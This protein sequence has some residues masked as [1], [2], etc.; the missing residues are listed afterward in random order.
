MLYRHRAAVTVIQKDDGGWA[1][2]LTRDLDEDM[3]AAVRRYFRRVGQVAT[4]D[5][6]SALIDSLVSEDWQ[7]ADDTLR[8]DWEK[9]INSAATRAGEQA[10]EAVGSEF[11]IDNPYTT[12]WLATHGSE[13]ITHISDET[14]EAVRRAIWEGVADHRAPKQIAA[15]LRKQNLVGLLP[16]HLQAVLTQKAAW[17]AE[18]Y[19]EW[20]VAEMAAT[21]AD[22]LLNYR[23]MNIA[24]TEVIRGLAQGTQ[25]SWLVARQEGL[26]L[27]QTRKVWLS[28]KG[29]KRTCPICKDLHRVEAPLDGAFI[30]PG[31]YTAHIPPAHPG[32]RCSMGLVTRTQEE[33]EAQQKSA[34][35]KLVYLHLPW[36]R[37]PSSLV[38]A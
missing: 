12:A 7:A 32:C 20:E 19:A 11:L 17:L 14:R 5:S 27:P 26:L 1:L 4:G 34:P 37:F 16:Q 25:D 2:E 10:A 6:V 24:R 23:T 9:V 30:S 33:L 38:A 36:E 28:A 35:R 21:Y 29:D 8:K 18:G 31:G 13:L 3:A 22:D 15:D